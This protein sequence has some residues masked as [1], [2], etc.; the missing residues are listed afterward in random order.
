MSSR[1]TWNL[2]CFS[3]FILTV[4]VLQLHCLCLIIGIEKFSSDMP[5][6][7][8]VW[9][10]RLSGHGSE[11]RLSLEY[12]NTFPHKRCRRTPTMRLHQHLYAATSFIDD[13]ARVSVYDWTLSSYEGAVSIEFPTDS[14]PVS[15][16][17]SFF[18]KPCRSIVLSAILISSK[19]KSYFSCSGAGLSSIASLPRRREARHCESPEA[20]FDYALP[21]L[22]SGHSRIHTWGG[23]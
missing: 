6:L 13:K 16:F 3:C 15:Y 9:T 14:L 11:A 2:H 21:D 5:T 22:I 19:R 23:T 17:D 4:S 7:A 8:T 1:Q 10:G 20:L 12:Q 18:L